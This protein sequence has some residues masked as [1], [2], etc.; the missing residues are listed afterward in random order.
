MDF[1][2]MKPLDNYRLHQ[3]HLSVIEVLMIQKIPGKKH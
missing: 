1:S 2:R 3:E